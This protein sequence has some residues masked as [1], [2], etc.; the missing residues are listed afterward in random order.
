VF[1]RVAWIERWN[2]GGVEQRAADAGCLAGAFVLARKPAKVRV[3]TG[4]VAAKINANGFLDLRAVDIERRH[5]YI[6]AKNLL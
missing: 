1:K 5:G 4:F 6:K 3:A 2:A